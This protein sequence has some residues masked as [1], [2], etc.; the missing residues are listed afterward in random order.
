MASV[1]GC[2]VRNSFSLSKHRK[3]QHATCYIF[4]FWFFKKK[5]VQSDQFRYN[6]LRMASFSLSI[7]IKFSVI[8]LSALY[9]ECIEKYYTILPFND[10]LEWSGFSLSLKAAAVAFFI[11][12]FSHKRNWNGNNNIFEIDQFLYMHVPWYILS[13]YFFISS[14][15]KWS[16]FYSNRNFFALEVEMRASG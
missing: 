15:V 7:L 13:I 14:R 5:N 1:N 8:Q 2:F 4:F 12:L 3:E 11:L 16:S 10:S 9:R 6:Q